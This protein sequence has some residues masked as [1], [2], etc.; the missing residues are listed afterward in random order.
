MFELEKDWNLSFAGCGFLSIYQ[1]GVVSCL[2][3]KA[4]QLIK[5]AS[6]VYGSSSGAMIA[7][8]LVSEVS[9]ASDKHRGAIPPSFRGVRYVDGAISDNVPQYELKNTIT[10]SPFSGESDICP[11][12]NSTN[13]HELRIMN[14]SIQFSL[15]NLYRVS[16]V[17]FPPE[18]KILGEMCQQGYKDALKFLEKSKDFFIY[19]FFLI[20]LIHLMLL[21]FKGHSLIPSGLPNDLTPAEVKSVTPS[22]DTGQ[23]SKVTTGNEKGG[24]ELQSTKPT[25]EKPIKYWLLNEKILENLSPELC[26]VLHEACKEKGDLYTQLTNLLPLRLAS[27]AMLPCTLPVESAYSVALRFVDWLPD[28][29]NDVRWIQQQLYHVAGAVVGQARKRLTLF[30]F[31]KENYLPLRKSLT[32]PTSLKL[33][34]PNFISQP[35]SISYVDLKVWYLEFPDHIKLFWKH[36]AITQMLSS[37]TA[38]DTKSEDSLEVTSTFVK[39][40]NS[41]SKG[42]PTRRGR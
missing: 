10:I 16:Q 42:F 39:T 27:Y 40:L 26:E 28:F 29:P 33:Q 17:L 41:S 9:L 38:P 2:L 25:C 8:A 35:R 23:Q 32:L 3:E 14:T 13:F 30:A 21:S 15:S 31:R 37:N 19:L 4:P 12:D 22:C 11:K 18:P 6:K 20:E 1:V 24:E 5:N 36:N 7:A 34:L